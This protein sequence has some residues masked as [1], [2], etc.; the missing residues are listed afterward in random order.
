MNIYSKIAFVKPH[1]K[2]KEIQVAFDRKSVESV[3]E[4]ENVKNENCSILT[5]IFIEMSV[6][7]VMLLINC[8]SCRNVLLAACLKFF[9]HFEL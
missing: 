8:H 7:W 9:H 2:V 1:F 5:N 3:R 4:S 6:V